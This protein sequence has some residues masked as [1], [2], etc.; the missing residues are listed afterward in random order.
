MRKNISNV[1]SAF[2]KGFAHSERTC[3]TDGTTIKS[4]AMTIA[5]RNLDGSVW[6][7]DRG[8]APSATTRGQ[9]DAVRRSF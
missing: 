3:S 4:Y 6:V 1:I 9:I 2:N 8:E 7:I 5:E